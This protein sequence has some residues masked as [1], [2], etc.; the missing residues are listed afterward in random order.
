MLLEVDRVASFYGDFQALFEVSL[1]VAEGETVA[2]IG[3]TGPASRPCCAPWSA[4]RTGPPAPSA[5]TA[6]RWTGS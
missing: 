2:V 6:A 1:Q 4:S 3:P 5:S